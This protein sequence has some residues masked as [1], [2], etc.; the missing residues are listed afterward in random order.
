MGGQQ[1]GVGLQIPDQSLPNNSFR[2]RGYQFPGE[3]RGWP[4]RATTRGGATDSRPEPVLNLV[5]TGPRETTIRN[6]ANPTV[7]RNT[8]E[9]EL[10]GIGIKIEGIPSPENPRTGLLV[11]LSVLGT[12]KRRTAHL[13]V[14]T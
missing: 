2:G 8:Y 3:A 10:G 13:R 7:E 14:G 9:G 6:P 1:H 5:W 4:G 12:L 11:V